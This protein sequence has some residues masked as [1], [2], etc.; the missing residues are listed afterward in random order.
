MILKNCDLHRCGEEEETGSC[1]FYYKN[2]G[3]SN[4]AGGRQILKKK[5]IKGNGSSSS[6]SWLVKLFV[7]RCY[8]ITEHLYD[9]LLFSKHLSDI[10]I[11]G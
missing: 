3:T 4:E 1:A 10:V 11:F 8:E 2:C 7:K 5:K 6:G 9:L